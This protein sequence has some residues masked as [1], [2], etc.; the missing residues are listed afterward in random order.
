M[1]HV[2]STVRKC[3]VCGVAPK[4]TNGR[5]RVRRSKVKVTEGRNYVW[6]PGGDIVLDPL[7]RVNSDGNVAFEKGAG[8]VAHSFN[9]IPAFVHMRGL[10]DALVNYFFLSV[11]K[12][13]KSVGTFQDGIK[14]IGLT[15]RVILY[16]QPLKICFSSRGEQKC[17]FSIFFMHRT[18]SGV[19]CDSSVGDT[20]VVLRLSRYFVVYVLSARALHRVSKKLCIFVSV[21]TTSNF[22]EF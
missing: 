14:Q 16:V 18:I 13:Y 21:I 22:H 1:L 8:G 5:P 10:A 6:K 12:L 2:K 11:P 19:S 4:S 9:C 17:F 3:I 20:L 7:S 15:F